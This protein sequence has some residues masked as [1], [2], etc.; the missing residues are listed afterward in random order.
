MSYSNAFFDL[1]R[2]G[3]QDSAAVVAPLIWQDYQPK[4]VIDVGCGEG[5][6][7][8]A[9]QD[10]G[11]PD[12]L[13]VDGDYIESPAIP[14]E[15]LDLA[16]PLPVTLGKWDL[17]I[18]LEVAEHLPRRSADSFVA[19]L[20]DLAPVI[21]FSAAIPK[22]GGVN[23]INEQWPEYWVSRF[24]NMGYHCSGALRWQIWNDNRVENWYRQN[25]MLVIK[26]D[27]HSGLSKWMHSL[28]AP[29]WPVVH[30]VLFDARAR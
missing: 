16:K 15:K 22:Q 21:L 25:L 13:G 7:G 1:I 14:L 30:P 18:A 2:Q 11:A 6:W 5:W 10:L 29:M 24:E 26:Q 17:A 3:C 27:F 23:H 4:R 28:L 8:K 12:V 19:D 9:F 20:C